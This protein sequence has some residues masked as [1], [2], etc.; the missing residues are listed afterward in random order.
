MGVLVVAVTDRGIA[1]PIV[2]FP[3]PVR[4][5]QL[6]TEKIYVFSKKS[7][8]QPVDLIDRT[9]ALCEKYPPILF[10]VF[11]A[12]HFVRVRRQR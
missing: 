12:Q 3:D 6:S 10:L 9:R 7:V 2:S 4:I 1:L 8:A 11:V 5:E